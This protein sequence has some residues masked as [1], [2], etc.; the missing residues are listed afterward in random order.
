[1]SP[2]PE[3]GGLGVRLLAGVVFTTLGIALLCHPY[4]YFARGKMAG[5]V[6]AGEPRGGGAWAF[7]LIALFSHVDE[8]GVQLT[9]GSFGPSGLR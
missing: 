1:M 6:Q 2:D 3:R 7:L 4:L 9:F 8:Y 5:S